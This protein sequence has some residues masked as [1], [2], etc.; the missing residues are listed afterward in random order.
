M[1]RAPVG[2]LAVVSSVFAGSVQAEPARTRISNHGQVFILAG[3]LGEALSPGLEALANKIRRRGIPV[4]LSGHGAAG[5]RTA[6]AIAAWNA[7]NHGAIVIIGHSLGAS[8][9]M[10]MARQLKEQKIPVRLV[11]SIAPT[12]DLEV[13]G[14]VARVVNYYQSDGASK[15]KATRGADFRG[16]INNIDLQKAADVNHFNMVQRDS[17]HKD[18]MS[19]VLSLVSA[20]RG[21]NNPSQ[22]LAVTRSPGHHDAQ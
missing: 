9:A 15:G 17:V 19:R 20:T 14:N 3:L 5:G 8:A 10:Q 6:D 11:V 12:A 7:G 16:T 18:T 22:S 4:N 1:W 13:P 21:Q 2:A